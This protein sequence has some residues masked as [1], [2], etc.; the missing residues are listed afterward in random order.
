MDLKFLIVDTL[1]KFHWLSKSIWKNCY[2]QND[3]HITLIRDAIYD[4]GDV[5][6]HKEFIDNQVKNPTKRLCGWLTASIVVGVSAVL[7]VLLYENNNMIFSTLSSSIATL[8]VS[9]AS[10]RPAS[11]NDD[12]KPRG[13]GGKRPTAVVPSN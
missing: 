4:R 10:I 1:W 8:N 7:L 2:F 5:M 11:W 12:V 6:K 9:L 3:N 13:K